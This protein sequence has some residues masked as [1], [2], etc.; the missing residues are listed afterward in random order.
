MHDYQPKQ[1]KGGEP[2]WFF[3][4]NRI[5]NIINKIKHIDLRLQVEISEAFEVTVKNFRMRG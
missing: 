5:E 2:L 3:E 4:R 1:D